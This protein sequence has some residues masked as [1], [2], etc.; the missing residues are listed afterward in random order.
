MNFNGRIE[1]FRGIVGSHNYNLN[2]KTSDKDYKVFVLPTFDDLYFGTQF[3]KSYVSD[4]EDFDCHDIRKLSNLLWKS[5][6]NFV[7]ILF[8]TELTINQNLSSKTIDI[9]NEIFLNKE[10]IARMNLPYL[11]NACIGMCISKQK[12]I[13]KGTS[14]TQYLVDKYGYDTKA[15]MSSIRILDFLRRYSENKFISFQKAIKYENN[16]NSRELLL[17]IKNGEYNK[18]EI[19]FIINKMN[20]ILEENFKEVY[21]KN[22]PNEHTKDKL[23]SDIKEIIKIEIF[24]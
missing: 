4:V 20:T 23:V 7:E 17:D 10:E 24:K 13:D 9:I 6:V 3:S 14:N 12:I 16:D 22:N 2:T 8:S 21:Y 5:N 18:N 11:Y 19:L 1:L 15:A